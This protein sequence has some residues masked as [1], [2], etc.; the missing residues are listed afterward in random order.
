V[1]HAKRLNELEFVFPVADA[2]EQGALSA[3]SLGQLLAK[4]ARDAD[5]RAYAEQLA[6]LRFS[7]LRGFLRGFIDLALEH[8]DRYYIIDYKSNRLG[9]TA[10]EYQ[11]PRMLSE[12]RRHHY[13]LQYLLYSVALHRYLDLRLRGYD[14][15]LHFGGVYYLFVRGMSTAHPPGIGVLFERPSRA[16]IEELSEVLRRPEVLS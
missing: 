7:P 8:A 11:R 1:P 16:L 15:D 4:H 9:E 2:A 10:A 13:V 3:R 12:M 6:R 14:Y 5:E